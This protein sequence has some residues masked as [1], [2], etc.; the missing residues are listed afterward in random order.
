MATMTTRRKWTALL[1]VTAVV[2]TL[3]AGAVVW[4]SWLKDTTTPVEVAEAI[5]RFEGQQTPASAT[6]T[7]ALTSVPEPGVYV[8]ATTGSEGVDALGGTRHEYPGQTTITVAAAPCGS[9]YR[10]VPLEERF[11]DWTVCRSGSDM[12][13][14]G[15]TSLHRFF[16]QDTLLAYTC[17][18]PLVL[19]PAD[20][21]PGATASTSCTTGQ[22]TELQTA[23]VQTVGSIEV[24]GTPTEAATVS[25]E[26]SL[27]A[28][29]GS[30][31]GTTNRTVVFAVQTGLILRWSEVGATVAGSPIGDVRFDETF[32]LTITSLDPT[33]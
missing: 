22:E 25:I 15:Y 8:Y 7:A 5:D 26:V 9:S 14:V 12:V 16:G 2:V 1:V 19:V 30:I 11:D 20:P 27:S 24:A 21:K 13:L 31:T 29:D 4:R 32:E 10:W 3:G 6:G 17:D 33:S 18:E 28:S 23:T